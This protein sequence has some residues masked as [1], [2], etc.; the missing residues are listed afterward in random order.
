MTTTE[1]FVQTILNVGPMEPM[2]FIKMKAFHLCKKKY[3]L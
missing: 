1:S 2:T 3:Q